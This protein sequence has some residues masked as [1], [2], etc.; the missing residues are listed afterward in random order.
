MKIL[1]L[2]GLGAIGYLSIFIMRTAG[3]LDLSDGIFYG[4][5]VTTYLLGVALGLWA[6]GANH[7]YE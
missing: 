1:L 5:A 2:L 4:M 7:S 3:I 6:T